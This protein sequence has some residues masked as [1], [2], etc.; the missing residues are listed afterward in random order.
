MIFNDCLV[1]TPHKEKK[2]LNKNDVEEED[3]YDI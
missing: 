1:L 3:L 2:I